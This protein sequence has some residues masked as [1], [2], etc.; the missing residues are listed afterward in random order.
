MGEVEDI[1]LEVAQDH[2]Q[3]LRAECSRLYGVIGEIDT[4]PEW[5]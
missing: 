4:K 1:V 2:V 3:P 5:S